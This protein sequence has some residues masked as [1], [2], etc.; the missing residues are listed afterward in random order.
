MFNLFYLFIFFFLP[1]LTGISANMHLLRL[2]ICFNFGS[3]DYAEVVFKMKRTTRMSQLKK[4]Y[5]KR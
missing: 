3:Q 2:R 5:A 1:I 4:T